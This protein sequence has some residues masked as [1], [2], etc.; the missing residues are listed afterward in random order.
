[1][2]KNN[3]TDVDTDNSGEVTEVEISA[4]IDSLRSEAERERLR[5]IK[6]EEEREAARLKAE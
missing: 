1:M 4:F 5:M 2:V 6:E 3:F